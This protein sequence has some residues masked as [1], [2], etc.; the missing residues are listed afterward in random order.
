MMVIAGDNLLLAEARHTSRQ[1]EW[2]GLGETDPGVLLVM[3]RGYDPAAAVRDAAR[4]GD[5]LCRIAPR[6]VARGTACVLGGSDLF[7]RSGPRTV[8]GVAV[9]G[10]IL[11]PDRIPTAHLDRSAVVWAPDGRGGSL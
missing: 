2:G 6:A 4:Q 8:D 3:P 10:A 5:A 11:H 9:L 7:N 1:V